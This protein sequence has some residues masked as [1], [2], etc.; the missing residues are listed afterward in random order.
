MQAAL[1]SNQLA[2]DGDKSVS[3]K[4]SY[5]IP[6]PHAK[7][8]LAPKDYADLY[9]PGSYQ[10]PVTYVRSTATVEDAICGPAYNLEEEDAEWL[11]ARNEKAQAA[12]D[13]HLKELKPAALAKLTGGISAKGKG[14]EQTPSQL[15]TALGEENVDF[16]IITEDELEMVMTVFEHVATEQ[17]P[18]A[19][20]DVSKLP[21]EQDLITAFE[22]QSA[23]SKRFALPELDELPWEQGASTSA[24][25]L[26]SSSKAHGWSTA[27]PWKNLHV[28]KPLVSVVYPW[29]KERRQDRDG[30]LVIPQLNFDE[31]N[32]SD[33]YVCFRRREVKLTR[34]TRKTDVLHLEKLLKLRAEMDHVVTLLENLAQREKTKRASLAQDRTWWETTRDL[35][36]IKRIWGVVGPNNGQEDE[37]LI[38][39]ANREEPGYG[40]GAA[41]KKRKRH[42]EAA[43]AQAA[44]AQAASLS[45]TKGSF[46]RSRNSLEPGASSSSSAPATQ[47]LGQAIMER[48]QAVQAYIDRECLRKAETDLG[49]EEGSDTAYQPV[50]PPPSIRSFRPIQSDTGSENASAFASAPSLRAGRPPSFRRRIGRGGRVFLDRRLL[51]ASPVPAHLA[52]WPGRSTTVRSSELSREA[53]SEQQRQQQQRL[54][55]PQYGTASSTAHSTSALTGPF[56]FD[57]TLRPSLLSSS[58]Y[59]A[60]DPASRS[61]VP[62]STPLRD[63]DSDSSDSIQSESSPVRSK[64]SSSSPPSSARGSPH[65]T[66]PDEDVDEELRPSK[67]RN[68]FMSSDESDSDSSDDEEEDEERLRA[69]QERWRYDDESGRWAGLGLTGLGGMEDDDEAV[70]DDF[71]QRFMRYRMTLLEEEDLHKLSTDWTHIMQAQV[72]LDHPPI[73]PH[74]N[75]VGPSSAQVQA[76]Q[77]QQAASAAAAAHRVNLEGTSS[78]GAASAAIS[79]NAGNVQAQIA[80]AQAHAQ[81]VRQQQAAALA[82]AS[83]NGSQALQNG[84]VMPPNVPSAMVSVPTTAGAVAARAAHT[85][86]GGPLSALQLQQQQQQ[87]MQLALAFQQQQRQAVALAQAQAQAQGRGSPNLQQQQQAMAR[88]ASGGAGGAAAGQAHP[89]AQAFAGMP[90]ASQ[91]QLANAAARFNGFNGVSGNS[92]AASSPQLQ[93]AIANSRPSSSPAPG[94]G[95]SPVLPNGVGF[96]NGNQQ[97]QRIS[98]NFQGQQQQLPFNNGTNPIQLAQLQAAVQAAMNNN[99]NSNGQGAANN[100]NNGPTP[101]QVLQMQAVLA[102][103]GMGQGSLQL[104]LPANRALQ[105]AANGGGGNNGGGASSNG[106]Q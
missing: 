51:A 15:V 21:S 12:A 91:Q 78:A 101:A 85:N 34:K 6:T 87:Q 48:A 45:A 49:W 7:Q 36:E 77:Q 106:G 69:H 89:L 16:R 40:V 80:A 55:L 103:Q 46:K 33:P 57:P 44:A 93:A 3:S 17:V 11:Q 65:Q 39:A 97:Q 74:V 61:F 82:I 52:D 27:N 64:D 25:Q 58:S 75:I 43:A 90:N 2:A 66:E 22:P 9:P 35:Q 79:T 100:G 83:V 86:V 50:P 76:A 1:S 53:E 59:P 70:V 28:L 95:S 73:P 102:A 68:D 42:E 30:K 62:I 81:Q 94:Q 18:Y 19:H 92:T 5:H 54:A 60:S 14:R 72:A 8:L 20:L 96:Q 38:S 10:D 4:P 88:I 32:D 104:K 29:W 63:G 105:Q 56:A 24:R 41:P 99:N 23:V 13:A 26:G 84:P 31:S 47:S 37:E 67:Q 98:G 71:D